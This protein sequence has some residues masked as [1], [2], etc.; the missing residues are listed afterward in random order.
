MWN[1]RARV[2]PRP[3]HQVRSGVLTDVGRSLAAAPLDNLVALLAIALTLALPAAGVLWLGQFA[4]LAQ[5]PHGGFKA[6]PELTVF[7]PTTAERKTTL[8]VEARLRAL[9]EVAHTRLLAREDTLARMKSGDGQGGRGLADAIEV[10]PANPFPDA[11]VVVAADA[12]PDAL[13]RL[14]ASVR[15]WREVE[16][17][18]V[19]ADWAQRLAALV[20]FGR[21]MALLL[22][23]ALGAGVLLTCWAALRSARPALR[24]DPLPP[25]ASVLH[26]A[27][28]GVTGAVLAWALVATA[29]VW[30]RPQLAEVAALYGFA[31]DLA[32]PAVREGAALV[33]AAAL[34]GAACGGLSALVRQ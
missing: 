15:D 26:G 22:G 32:L 25:A 5:G 28:L 9:P 18:L 21:D 11:I 10:L 30:L 12:A 34:I 19:D 17:V 4:A 33:G 24:C 27:L 2:V 23:A 16:H 29:T 8:A 13:Q 1:A 14:A 31:F 7:M 6:T 20:R 3:G